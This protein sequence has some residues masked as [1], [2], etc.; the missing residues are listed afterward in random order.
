[1]KK[2]IGV[3]LVAAAIGLL[4]AARADDPSLHEVYQAVH[5]GQ[6]NEAQAMMTRVLRD[7]PDSAKAHYVEAEVLARLGRAADAQSELEQAER[8][9]PGLPFAKPEGVRELRGLIAE[10]AQGH[11]LVAE[12]SAASNGRSSDASIPWGPLL[13]VGGAALLIFLVLRAR[14]LSGAAAAGAGLSPAGAPYGAPNYGAAPM[15][16]PGIGSSV[17]GGLATGAAVGA[18]MVAGE[19]LAHEFLGNRVRP[20]SDSASLDGSRTASDDGGG[21]DFGISD[22]GS[23]DAGSSDFG[24]DGGGGGDWG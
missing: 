7:H 14:R 18:G 9:S 13:I 16:G 3:A 10:V 15:G 5:A 2:L 24:G 1:M 8:L 11:V 6:L 12:R 22:A 23:W 21:Q 17:V 4:P 19:A 20:A